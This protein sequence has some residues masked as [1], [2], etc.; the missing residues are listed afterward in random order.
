V[1]IGARQSV[2]LDKTHP[3]RLMTTRGLHP[4]THRI[5][6]QVNG[7]PRGSLTFELLAE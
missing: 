5:T 7:Q 2:T 4:G 1:E 6:V 3:M